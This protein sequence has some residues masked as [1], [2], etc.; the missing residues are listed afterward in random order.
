MLTKIYFKLTLV[1][2]HRLKIKSPIGNCEPHAIA[3]N[4]KQI[5]FYGMLG[6]VAKS[7]EYY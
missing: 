5:H 3:S 7:K 6:W 4:A 1:L 2:L